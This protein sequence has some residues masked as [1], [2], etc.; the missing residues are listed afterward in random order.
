MVEKGLASSQEFVERARQIDQEDGRA[1]GR[2]PIGS[3]N[4]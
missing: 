1:D 3:L 4:A 2:S